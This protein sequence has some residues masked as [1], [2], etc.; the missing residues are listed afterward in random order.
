MDSKTSIGSKWWR[1]VVLEGSTKVGVE[2]IPK[3]VDQFTVHA[4][5]LL[6]WN[7]RINL[8]T[9]TDPMDVAIKHFIDSVSIIPYLPENKSILDVGAGG[10][11]PG[12]PLAV[13]RPDL[14]MTLVDA[15]AKK[16]SFLKTIIRELSLSNCQ[17]HHFRVAAAPSIDGEE[18]GRRLGRFDAIVSRA[19]SDPEQC[20]RLAI[21]HLRANGS[22]FMMQGHLAHDVTSN[23]AV[24]C[25]NLIP[26]LETQIE[27]HS[28][29]LP[30][31][32]YIRHLIVMKT[33]VNRL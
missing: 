24:L 10:G 22:I 19:L 31:Q 30:F 2:L 29:R 6:N 1:K 16:V 11:F 23:L 27:I 8:T 20:L 5:H 26:Q 21:S 14:T 25:R 33:K 15:V 32:S 9:I 12:I 13:A 3:M 7:R 18:A 28:I 17:A 4:E